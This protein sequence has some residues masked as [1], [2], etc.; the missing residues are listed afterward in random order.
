MPF[1]HVVEIDL[2]DDVVIRFVYSRRPIERYA[3]LL[4]VRVNALWHEARLFD[5]H[6]GTH[7]MH[8]YTQTGG[9]QS[10]EIFHPGPANMAI[11]AAI[12]HLKAHWEGDSRIMEKG[13]THG[14]I[15]EEG[16]ARGVNT[17]AVD[18]ALDLAVRIALD[19]ASD[20]SYPSDLV[21]IAADLPHVS[22][23]LTRAIGQRR[24]LALV[25]PDGSN[26]VAQPPRDRRLLRSLA[27]GLLRLADATHKRGDRPTFVPREWVTQ[28]HAAPPSAAA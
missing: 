22:D 12:D 7:H 13:L 18:A 16:L 11:P 25:F 5:N 27:V 10:P 26:L 8:R 14:G 23:M 21:L 9:K 6:L 15:P 3:V 20:E 1:D 17:P 2:D 24:A 19:P 28:F 4:L